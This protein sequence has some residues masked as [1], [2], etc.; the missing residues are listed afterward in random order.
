MIGSYD[1]Y[2]DMIEYKPYPLLIICVHAVQFFQA[3]QFQFSNLSCS[4]DRS[5]K[6][7]DGIE[8]H[9]IQSE[10]RRIQTDY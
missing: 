10:V 7:I 9:R 3:V 4:L 1:R 2:I 5:K 6:G 8:L